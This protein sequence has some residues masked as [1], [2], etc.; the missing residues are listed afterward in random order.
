MNMGSLRCRERVYL[1]CWSWCEKGKKSLFST[2]VAS[3]ISFTVK[4]VK[5]RVACY[6]MR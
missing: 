5:I 2:S 6:D 3:H 1:H 4:I